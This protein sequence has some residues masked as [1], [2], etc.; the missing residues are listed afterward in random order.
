MSVPRESFLKLND[1]TWDAVIVGAG[2]GGASVAVRLAAQGLRVLLVEAKAFPR[3]KV[4]GGCLNQRAWM[5]LDQILPRGVS[6]SITS[7]IIAAGAVPIDRMRLNCLGQEALWSTPTMQAISRR[8]LDPILVEAAVQSGAVF[9]SETIA[10]IVDDEAIEFRRVQ[11]CHASGRSCFINSRIAIVADGLG[12]SSLSEF[13]ELTSRVESGARIGLGATFEDRSD[14]YQP[15]EL[16]MAVGRMGYVGLAR[17]EGEK[18]NVA[19]AI[20]VAAM[21]A[22]GPVA[23]V[24]SILQSCRLPVPKAIEEARWVGTLPLT[25]TSRVVAA[26]RLF[27][28]GDAAGYVEPF[29]GEGMSWSIIDALNLSEL[30][31]NFGL[32]DCRRLEVAWNAQWHS[33]LKSKQWVC[34][35]LAGLLRRPRAASVSLI[36]ARWVPWIPQWLIARASGVNQLTMKSGVVG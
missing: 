28:V 6:D 1:S 5:G 32:D 23:V 20:D 16:T 34:R 31:T 19:A 15:H 25:R 12:Q 2:T 35:G 17:V 26:R 30:I 11:L 10:K 13:P 14:S 8:T 22:L 21:K 3:D 7:R 29:T 9:C 36:A 33:K 4:C 18:L 27:K 24:A